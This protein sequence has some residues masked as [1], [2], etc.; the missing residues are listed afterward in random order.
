MAKAK[1]QKSQKFMIRQ[2]DVL[3]M[4]AEK[5]KAALAPIPDEGGRTILAHGEVTGHAHAL[6][7]VEAGLFSIPGSTNPYLE[8]GL[9]GALLRHEEHTQIPIAK[10]IHRVIRQKEYRYGE[11][12]RVED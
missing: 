1:K 7:A 12:R 3:V 5:P 4:A 6:S 10:G 2:G 8:V 11:S 9:D